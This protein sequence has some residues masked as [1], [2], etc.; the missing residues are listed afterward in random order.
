MLKQIKNARPDWSYEKA[1]G[2]VS[3]DAKDFVQCL[4]AKEPERR[5]T[6]E[7]AL[8]HPW[9]SSSTMQSPSHLPCS[10]DALSSM[11]C[12]AAGSRMRRLALQM[13]A[14]QL[15]SSTTQ[16]LRQSFCCIDQGSKGWISVQEFSDA[17]KQGKEKQTFT[18]D[19]HSV[20]V[21]DLFAALDVKRN[22]RIYYS[23]FLA[24]T[25]SAT[26]HCHESA[27]LATFARMDADHSGAIGPYD[28]CESWGE[29]FEGVTMQEVFQ[30]ARPNGEG[31]RLKELAQMIY[32]EQVLQPKAIMRL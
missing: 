31:I 11:Q 32:G 7:A 17:I 16:E 2:R 24:A 5:P 28:L 14:R 9:L 1:W 13:F 19:N 21:D 20:R 22:Q 29:E 12:Y 15:G 25:A 18:G 23:D 3:Q 30:E 4:L 26:N 8:R 27:F 10:F 6:A